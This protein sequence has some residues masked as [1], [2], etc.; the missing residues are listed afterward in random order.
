MF[1]HILITFFRVLEDFFLLLKLHYEF[2]DFL[3][4][5]LFD[6]KI[7]I[8]LVGMMTFITCQELNNE[9]FAHFFC[10]SASFQ[11]IYALDES[12]FLVMDVVQMGAGTIKTS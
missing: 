8:P 6:Q 5:F 7:F 10:G 1:V 12:K 4:F 9:V 2:S 11:L 3:F